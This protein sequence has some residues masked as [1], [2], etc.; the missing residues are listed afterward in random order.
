MSHVVGQ[1]R[2]CHRRS[3]RFN[4]RF[5]TTK[6][7]LITFQWQTQGSCVLGWVYNQPVCS[8]IRRAFGVQRFRTLNCRLKGVLRWLKVVPRTPIT[9]TDDTAG[10]T[11]RMSSRS[12][13]GILVARGKSHETSKYIFEEHLL[14]YP[15]TADSAPCSVWRS[16]GAQPSESLL[17]RDSAVSKQFQTPHH[18][19]RTLPGV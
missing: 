14:L 2:V 18:G 10:R 5:K 13:T 17:Q 1:V 19:A 9:R 11:G 6:L 12:R 15:P 16:I 8:D 4:K 3:P 7:N